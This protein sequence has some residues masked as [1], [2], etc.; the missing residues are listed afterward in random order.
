MNLD[1]L[2]KIIKLFDKSDKTL[3]VSVFL[4][5]FSNFLRKLV[6]QRETSAPADAEGE[7]SADESHGRGAHGR[8]R[9]R[10][11]PHPS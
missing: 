3:L 10:R 6:T 11:A 7:N 2:K 1:I 4:L 8:D 5:I 9:V